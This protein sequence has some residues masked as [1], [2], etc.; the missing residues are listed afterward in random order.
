[1]SWKN[2]S[3]SKKGLIIGVLVS[4]FI[5]LSAGWQSS[6]KNLSNL[7][8]EYKTTIQECGSKVSESCFREMQVSHIK[9][10]CTWLNKLEIDKNKCIEEQ[11]TTFP[12]VKFKNDIYFCEFS[13]LRCNGNGEIQE[14]N[15]FLDA[16]LK[17]NIKDGL[18]GIFMF[19]ILPGLIL[20]ILPLII[21]F[22]IGK[23]IE[24][25]KSK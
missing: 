2:L 15:L 21:G 23:I 12:I 17:P 10:E 3:Y 13:G 4:M 1:M 8:I 22:L 14:P 11:L 25:I 6:F 24:K 19:S 20:L 9:E 5:I 18:E 7:K 16:L